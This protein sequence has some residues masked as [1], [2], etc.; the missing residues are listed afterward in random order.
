MRKIDTSN[1]EIHDRTLSWLGIG[2]SIK[3]DGVQQ[4]QNLRLNQ[5]ITVLVCAANG[6]R[7]ACQP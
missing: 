4:C 1:K 3:S 2:T 7:T 6:G 5:I